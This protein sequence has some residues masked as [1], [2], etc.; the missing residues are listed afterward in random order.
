MI[1]RNKI[2]SLVGLYH[3]F[4]NIVQAIKFN[5]DY[6]IFWIVA[7]YSDVFWLHN[8]PFLVE[9]TALALPTPVKLLQGAQIIP[10]PL[11]SGM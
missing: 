2:P 6:S 10:G 1:T 11:M 5:D 7:L 3:H 4:G 8:I 9:C